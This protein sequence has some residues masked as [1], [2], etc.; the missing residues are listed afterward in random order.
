MEVVGRKEKQVDV[1]TLGVQQFQEASQPIN[2]LIGRFELN[3]D[4]IG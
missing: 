4:I 3:C 1:G 2:E